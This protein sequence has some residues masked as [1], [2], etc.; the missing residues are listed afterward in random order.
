MI[1]KCQII[2]FRIT[3]SQR[4]LSEALGN[5]QSSDD[6]VTLE[7]LSQSILLRNY[8]D[9]NIDL[10]KIIRTQIN[11]K[12]EEFDSYTVGEET[13]VTFTMK[14]FKALLTFAEALS[15]P[16]QIQFETTGKPIVFIVHN[17]T[18]LEAHFVLAT[19]KPDVSTQVS[20]QKTSTERN[21]RK[22]T[23]HLS[24]SASKK[25]HLDD[26][27]KCLDK[28]SHLFNFVDIPNEVLSNNCDNSV[29]ENNNLMDVKDCDDIPASPTSK[30]VIKSMF[31][32]C[33]ES[34]FDPRSIQSVVLADNSDGE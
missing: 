34:T 10:S 4:I 22:D 17:G 1:F 5:F 31:K 18:T 15:L 13:T 11:I 23:S 21:K 26:I 6:Q 19:T 20:T 3:S 29:I 24:E 27:S 33:F 25:P 14:E 2:V 7:A 28:D 9:D 8:I 32:R 16:I 12:A 30:T